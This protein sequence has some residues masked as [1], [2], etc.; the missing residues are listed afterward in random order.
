MT[1]SWGK[2]TPLLARKGV[3]FPQT[4]ILPP[5]RFILENRGLRGRVRFPLVAVSRRYERGCH[6]CYRAVFS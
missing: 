1:V 5:T 2:E 4:P 6:N 3:S